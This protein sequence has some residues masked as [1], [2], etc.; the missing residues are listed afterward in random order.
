MQGALWRIEEDCRSTLKAVVNGDDSDPE[1][2]SETQQMTIMEMRMRAAVLLGSRDEYRYWLS[3]YASF[4][5]RQDFVGRAE[6]LL[7]D[8][9]GP[10]YQ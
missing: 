5:A 1:W 3:Q 9:I 10:L 6:E 4:L 8:L 7:K 2:Y